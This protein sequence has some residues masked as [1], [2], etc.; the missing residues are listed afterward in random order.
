MV[1]QKEQGLGMRQGLNSNSKFVQVVTLGKL[2]NKSPHFPLEVQISGKVLA[3][4]AQCPGF[5]PE[6][7]GKK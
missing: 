3:Q 6:H 4:H 1:P 5:H 2:F 7:K